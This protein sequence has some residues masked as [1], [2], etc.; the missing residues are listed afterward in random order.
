MA[1]QEVEL[2]PAA[3]A[4]DLLAWTYYLKEN[5][6]KALEIIEQHVIDK[7][8]EPVAM[9][10]LAEI[11]KANGNITFIQDIKSA[12][13]ESSFELGLVMTEKIEQL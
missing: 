9:Y 12:L 3:Q 5:T 8:L 2:R 4:Y 1:Q 11:L 7:T 13:L 10:H 6:T